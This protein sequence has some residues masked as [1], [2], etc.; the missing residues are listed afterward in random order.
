[1]S[2]RLRAQRPSASVSITKLSILGHLQAN[3]NLTA[4]ELAALEQSQPQSLTRVLAELEQ[5]GLIS[6]VP[7]P[8]DRRRSIIGI[9]KDGTRVLV[10][11][12]RHRDVWLASAMAAKLT[13]TE[14]EV[15]RLAADMLE[16]LVE[17]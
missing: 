2:R 16:R 7:D 10:A 9:T 11:D 3:G 17:D 4:G 12:M 8:G 5:Q 6:R 13:P 14:R 1:M 15:L